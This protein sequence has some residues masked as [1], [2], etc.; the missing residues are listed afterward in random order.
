MS[1]HYRL[2]GSGG[3]MLT[4]VARYTHRSLQQC[5]MN[6]ARSYTTC[7]YV[8]RMIPVGFLTIASCS[9]LK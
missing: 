6:L 1:R 4:P 7:L 9:H 8:T 5:P 2:L 3:E